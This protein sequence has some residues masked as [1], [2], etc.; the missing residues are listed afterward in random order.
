MMMHLLPLLRA[1]HPRLLADLALG[2]VD[3]EGVK[4]LASEEAAMYRALTA[5]GIYLSQDRSDL[6]NVVKELSRG[7]SKPTEEDQEAFKRLSHVNLGGYLMSI[8]EATKR[9]FER[10]SHVNSRLSSRGW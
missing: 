1:A 7:M 2:A 10:L 6:A 3:E 9:Q 4:H 5:V 8:R